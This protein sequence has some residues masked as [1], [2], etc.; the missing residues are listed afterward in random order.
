MADLFPD[1]EI[2][3]PT[4]ST[5]LSS[6]MVCVKMMKES[7]QTIKN[8]KME[9]SAKVLFDVHT[10]KLKKMEYLRAQKSIKYEDDLETINKQLKRVNLCSKFFKK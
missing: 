5:E 9:S 3:E 4:E 8:K 6:L 2:I 10:P 7:A 1:F